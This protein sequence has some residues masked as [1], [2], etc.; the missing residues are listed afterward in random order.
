M[1][2]L[3]IVLGLVKGFA[4]GKVMQREEQLRKRQLNLQR[5]SLDQSQQR[6]DAQLARNNAQL[7]QQQQESQFRQMVERNKLMLTI[8]DT[9]ATPAFR[10]G[11][12]RKD[13]GTLARQGS[14]VSM[15]KAL[16][17][18][19]SSFEQ[20]AQ[21]ADPALVPEDDPFSG[22]VSGG[23]PLNGIHREPSDFSGPTSGG[24]ESTKR[25][26]KSSS[27]PEPQDDR[28]EDINAQ[29][30]AFLAQQVEEEQQGQFASAGVAPPS[31]EQ[32]ARDMFPRALDG[33]EIVNGQV[34]LEDESQVKRLR[35]QFD[36]AGIGLRVT[37]RNTLQENE[38]RATA[39]ED[40]ALA[41]INTLFTIE[42]HPARKTLKGAGVEF[43][44][45]GNV[46]GVDLTVENVGKIASVML[47]ET[48]NAIG[49]AEAGAA[50][51][52]G[53]ILSRIETDSASFKEM[54]ERH[55]NPATLEPTF[56]PKIFGMPSD[57]F[58]QINLALKVPTRTL[59]LGGGSF[60]ALGEEN[61]QRQRQQMRRQL[62]SEVQTLCLT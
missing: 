47:N 51:F 21:R 59:A 39:I 38:M 22:P 35:D 36:E 25:R 10:A 24:V 56:S 1:S 40:S 43:G 31:E 30:Q 33:V 48:D 37:D 4:Q 57:T 18:A 20:S 13:P 42:N 12:A 60:E 14:M 9:M 49:G 11:I 26:G 32:V 41:K 5:R 28:F 52:R 15:L 44:E 46:T 16:R 2:G 17:T 29:A 45:A 6:L 3:G 7:D 58:E 53:N 55:I 61:I 23:M 62:A 27:T 19:Q 54:F 34:I 8:N 50:W